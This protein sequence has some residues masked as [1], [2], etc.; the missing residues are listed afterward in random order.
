[1][2]ST[3]QVTGAS[4]VLGS[5]QA[6]RGASVD[7]GPGWSAIVGPNGAGK[8]TLL[9]AMA[10]LLPLAAGE[11]RIDGE[12]IARLAP[13]ARAARLAW[14]SQQA[15]TSGELTVREVVA[16]GRLPSTGLLGAL[17]NDDASR[18]DRAMRDAGC[19][20][21]HDRRLAEL[22]G[23][24]RQRVLVAR[25]L[26]VGAPVLLLDEPTTHLDPPFQ[27]AIVRLLR[28]QARAGVTVVSVLHDL[29]LALLADRLIVLEAGRV[30]AVGAS[31]DPRIH[32]E[33]VD[34]FGG[35]VRIVRFEGRWVVVPQLDA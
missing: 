32:R 4:V 7:A 31:D 28:E 16:L 17:T 25:A 19:D 33:L 15:D 29:S 24:E 5:T 18:I 30:R 35:T 2:T 13:A 6:L 27:V 34:V 12:N 21:A 14:L 23:G 26:A 10:G 1:M 11:V 9:R 20:A 8:S 22:S 3:L